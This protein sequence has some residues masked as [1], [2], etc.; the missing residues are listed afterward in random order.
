MAVA[1]DRDVVR[2]LPGRGRLRSNR[3]GGIALD[4]DR[5]DRPGLGV[6]RVELR[7]VAIEGHAAPK[8]LRSRRPR[9]WPWPSPS[10]AGAGSGSLVRVRPFSLRAKVCSR[11]P[12]PPDH[13]TWPD[14]GSSASPNQLWRTDSFATTFFS[15][16][17]TTERL[18]VLKPLV[19]ASAWRPSASGRIFSGR[20]VRVT[21]SPAGVIVQPL[22]R[23]NPLSVVP[24]SGAYRRPGGSGTDHGHGQGDSQHAQFSR[25]GAD[26]LG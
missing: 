3:A 7:A 5:R 2:P 13:Q 10:R 15:T 11:S 17:S 8:V 4:R 25:H 19:A 18:C 14:F 22:G 21:W 1:S 24:R 16:R 12:P 9:P 26:S 6:E 23:R 20:S